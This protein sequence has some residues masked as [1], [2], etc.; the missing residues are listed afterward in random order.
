[1]QANKL[2]LNIKKTQVVIFKAKNKNVNEPIKLKLNGQDIKQVESTK[3]L[4]I[5]I[6]S[7]LTWKQHIS[8]ITRKIS[9][10]SGI[11]CKARHYVSS[12]T[13]RMLYYTLIYPYILYGNIIWA[14]TYPSRLDKIRRIQKKI[15]R[16]KTFSGFSDPSAPL[17]KNLIILPIDD[18]NNE[19]LAIFMFK[20]FN[21]GLPESFQNFFKLNKDLHNYNT[22]SAFQVH[23]QR[24]RTNY[25]KYSTEYKGTQI[26]NNLPDD[27]KDS[28]SLNIFKKNIRK[29]YLIK[30]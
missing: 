22:R 16:L 23:K 20:Y 11:L 28:N 21:K 27:I 18:I 14:N 3:F 12:K 15:I 19:T 9:K 29:Y 2:S 13:S 4:G 8:Y 1:M 5:H 17:F 25:K 7:A 30:N 6:D 24:V 10:T 26:W